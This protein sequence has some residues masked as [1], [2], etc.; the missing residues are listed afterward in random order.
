MF[1]RLLQLTEE[2]EVYEVL[3]QEGNKTVR[4]KIRYL[5]TEGVCR[6]TGEI[7]PVYDYRPEREWRHLDIMGYKTYL[8]CRVP[9]VK[10]SIGKVSSIAVPWAEDDERHTHDFENYAIRILQ[11]TQNQTKAGE[12]LDVSYE[13]INRVMSNSVERG[14]SR[15]NLASDTIVSLNIDEKSY[16]KGHRYATVISEQKRKRVIEVGRDRTQESTETL[17]GEVFTETQ[18]ASIKAVCV[19][20]WNPFIGAIKKS[21]RVLRLCMISFTLSPT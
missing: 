9:R 15:R 1:R 19:D 3:Y 16:K 10:N 11:A 12:L 4:V 20:M 8:Y 14:L 18:L 13:K 6:E 17:L 21:V 7:C 5:R 2:W